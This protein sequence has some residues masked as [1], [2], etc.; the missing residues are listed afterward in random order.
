MSSL[1]PVSPGVYVQVGQYEGVVGSVLCRPKRSVLDRT[2]VQR[3]DKSHHSTIGLNFVVSAVT[4]IPG[5]VLTVLYVSSRGYFGGVS[6]TSGTI[7]FPKKK[8]FVSE[9]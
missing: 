1:L 7:S 6:I 5:K 2:G 9:N 8:V 3:S 4:L